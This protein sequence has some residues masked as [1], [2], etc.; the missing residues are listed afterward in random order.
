MEVYKHRILVEL[1]RFYGDLLINIE[2]YSAIKDHLSALASRMW[3]GVQA[4]NKAVLSEISNYHW[5]HLGKSTTILAS[6]GLTEEDCKQTIANE[7]GF[8]RWTEVMHMDNAYNLE[9]EYTVNDMLAG[10]ME[11]VKNRISKNKGLV[12]KK[13]YY[14][15]RATLLHYAASN[16]VE[17]WRQ[18]VP[19]NL[20]EIVAYLIEM[21]INKK[22]KMKV[23][24]VEYTAGELLLSS[25]HPYDAGLIDVLRPLF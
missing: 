4:E 18:K 7:Y 12:N 22:A 3:A 19:L 23:Y 1:E 20:P 2:D 14:G 6:F 8:R 5:S 15:H 11:I 10:N 9:F 24:G 16:G 21:G 25:A 13:S 17:L